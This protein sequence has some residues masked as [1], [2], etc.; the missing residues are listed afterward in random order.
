MAL[1]GA[2]GD[3]VLAL[4]ADT[5]KFQSDL[6]RADRVAKKFSQEVGRSMAS[7]ARQIALLAGAGGIGALVKSQIDA[8]DAAGKMAEKIGISVE[9]F[10]ALKYAA[11]ISEVG[12]ETLEKAMRKLA[13]NMVD[14]QAGTGEAREAFR[15]LGIS[16][17][18]AGG[19]LKQG[20]DILLELAESFK[21]MEG[22]AGKAAI[23]GKLFGERVGTQLIPFLNLGRAGIEQ[24]KKEAER[25]GV[26]FSSEAAKAAD[27]FNDS[28]T[29]LS[30]ATKGIAIQISGPL[31]NAL[32]AAVTA[33]VEARDR[34]D[35]FLATLGNILHRLSMGSDL[36]IMQREMAGLGDALGHARKEVEEA[37]R[38]VREVH[39]ALAGQAEKRVLVAVARLKQIE[40]RMKVLQGIMRDP[41][42]APSG[43]HDGAR[44]PDGP[45]VPAPI[46]FTDAEL[47]QMR[48]GTQAFI[49][50]LGGPLVQAAEEAQNRLEDMVFTW[51]A[52]GERLAMTKKEYEELGKIQAQVIASFVESAELSVVASEEMIYTWDQFGDRIAMT[53]EAFSELNKVTQKNLEFANSLGL[54]FTSAFEDAII[55]GS[56]FRDVLKGI[57]QDIARIILRQGVTIPVANAIGSTISTWFPTGKALG[58]PVSSG[59]PYMVGERGPELFVPSMSGT[60]VPNGSLGGGSVAIYQTINVDSRSDQASIALAMQRSKDAAVAEVTARQ[61]RRGDARIG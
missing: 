23:A 4:S 18:D 25:L 33:F 40:D 57:E 1:L 27:E 55:N 53:K 28:L 37:Q 30:N 45:K 41:F 61:Q 29:R 54:T 43:A 34:G 60:V 44:T 42:A 20:D 50:A 6:D 14:T 21:G 47:K 11:E 52:A 10:S 38:L 48:D 7:L 3:L 2:L 51:N 15:A 36:Q 24:L 16:V 32:N 31:V 56:K 9:S 13:V 22:G 19:K 26:V 59:T 39:P 49:D 8:A 5:A 58:G 35:G 17:V 46:I 12:V